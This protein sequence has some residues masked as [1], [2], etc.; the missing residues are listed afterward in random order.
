VPGVVVVGSG[1][2]GV[3]TAVSL[4]D[5]GYDR[6]VTLIGDE[7]GLPYQRPPL[8]KA[9]LLGKLEE[10]GLHLRAESFFHK[11]NIA[12]EDGRRATRI[13]RDRRRVHLDD[14]RA[15]DYEHLVLAT[16]TRNR[17]LRVAGSD[18]ADVMSLR[19]L[20]DARRLRAAMAGKRH[21]V[22]IGA[23]FIGMEF[24]AVAASVGNAVTV[25][26]AGSRVMGRSSSPEITEWFQDRHESRGVTFHFGANV[27]GIE[28]KD[29]RAAG[30]VTADGQH[31]PADLVLVGIG[32]VPNA[33]LAEKAGLAIHNGISV[34][35]HL[36]TSDPHISAIG[37]CASG[38]SVHAPGVL[39]LESV[40][41]AVDQ[42]KT[43]AARLTGN[44][45]PYVGVPWFWS[46]QGPDKLQI[47]GLVNDCS[48][49]LVVGS[50]AAGR[51]SVL[52]F[53]DGR[54]VGAESVNRP[55][56][57]MAARRLLQAG[58]PLDI[59]QAARAD[60]DLAAFV[61][62]HRAAA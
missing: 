1:Q 26:E 17:T 53:R 22:V 57:H 46:D 52:S 6:P 44:P 43:V 50:T 45:A 23:G 8:S 11:Q 55:T 28:G 29:G 34:D 32:V 51:F 47:A 41:N 24:A 60:F 21:A 48:Q 39:R 33:E 35:A 49:R 19:S 18:L 4:R 2:A 30:V 3:Q 10:T 58:I 16:G 5:M 36:S 37:D 9:Y 62:A 13:E 15:L 20:D 7:P 59:G 42:A 12:L 14:G 56:D 31:F 54:F 38:P 61:S 40:Q 25:I 27:V